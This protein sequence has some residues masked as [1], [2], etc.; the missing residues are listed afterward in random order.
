LSW[1]VCTP[2]GTT[3]V[4]LAVVAESCQDACSVMG[5]RS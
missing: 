5:G 1:K 2:G 3:S 4:G